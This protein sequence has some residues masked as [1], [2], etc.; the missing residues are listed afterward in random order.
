MNKFKK[1]ICIVLSLMLFTG[2]AD[3]PDEISKYAPSEEK[4][5]T[6]YTSHKPEIWEPVVRE[7]EERYGIWVDVYEGGTSEL[8]EEI[9]E[10]DTDADV[11]FGGGIESLMAFK[12]LFSPYEVSG[13]EYISHK[14]ISAENFY[15]PFSA[16]PIVLVYNP[17]L[18]SYGEISSWEDLLNEKFKGKIAFADPEKSGS[19]FTALATMLKALSGDD[20]NKLRDF[21]ENLDGKVYESSGAALESV[22]EGLASVG[23]SIEETAVKRMSENKELKVV[24]PKDGTSCVPDGTAIINN[25]PHRENAELFVDFTVSKAVQKLLTDAL[26]RR[27]I[28]IDTTVKPPLIALN[29]IKLISYDA[30][31][32]GEKRDILLSSWDFYLGGQ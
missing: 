32:A 17:K 30:A 14:Y 29:K 16:L 4:R 21:A 8:L 13:H 9:S 15:T 1:L 25:C 6:V 5:L 19:S 24:Y 2:C 12:N 31:K 22:C 10:G 20:E 18:V 28:R 7:F 11:M 27:S 23:I 3:A 26:L